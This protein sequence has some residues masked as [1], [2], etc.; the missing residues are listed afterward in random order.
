M[1]KRPS[2]V[3]LAFTMTVASSFA[4]WIGYLFIV[5]ATEFL[6][7]EIEKTSESQLEP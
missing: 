6:G 3:L 5:Q 4:I 2:N 1:M 7:E